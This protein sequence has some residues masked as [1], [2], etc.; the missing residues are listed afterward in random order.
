M[1]ESQG[2]DPEVSGRHKQ[3]QENYRERILGSV[4][5]VNNFERITGRGSW[6]QWE[7]LTILRELQGED[8][9]VSGRC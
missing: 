8:P 7:T 3:F 9:R 2:E 6:G 5:D 1:R 4:G